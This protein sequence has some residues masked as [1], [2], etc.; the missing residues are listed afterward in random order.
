M[1]WHY[2][3]NGVSHDNV[4]DNVI[5]SLFAHG[6]L[7][8]ATLVWR[9]GMTVWQSVFAS[10]LASVLLQIAMHQ[11]TPTVSDASGAL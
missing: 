5:T 10:P 2:E 9:Q 7:T 11:H 4:T 8:A 1:T 3:I 6:E